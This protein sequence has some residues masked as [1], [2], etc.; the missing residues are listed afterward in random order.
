MVRSL[1]RAVI[2]H[3]GIKRLADLVNLVVGHKVAPVVVLLV[4]HRL[5]DRDLPVGPSSPHRVP[6]VS[7]EP[8]GTVNG[9]NHLWVGSGPEGDHR[10]ER[11]F[12]LRL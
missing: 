1:V 4:L 8:A 3:V 7:V 12:R 10:N 11:Q 9:I 2:K 5:L 6:L